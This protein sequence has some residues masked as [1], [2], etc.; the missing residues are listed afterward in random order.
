M[1]LVRTPQNTFRVTG[2]T[3]GRA[4]LEIRFKHIVFAERV[5]GLR[6]STAMAVARD[7]VVIDGAVDQA[8]R[9]QR[10]IDAALARFVPAFVLNMRDRS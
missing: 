6:E 4:D 5:F 8:M 10:V 9:V 3:S 7:R 2:N 1:C